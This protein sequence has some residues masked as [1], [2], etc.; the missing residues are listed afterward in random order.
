[1]YANF[2]SETLTPVKA[3]KGML[4]VLKKFDRAANN[5]YLRA[6]SKIRQHIEALFSWLIENQT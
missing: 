6:L 1:M 3:V 4:Y 2:N 5:L